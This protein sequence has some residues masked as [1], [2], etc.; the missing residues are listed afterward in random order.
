[1]ELLVILLVQMA[2]LVIQQATACHANII[3]KPAQARHLA[4][5]AIQ[6]INILW[7]VQFKLAKENISFILIQFRI[8]VFPL[9]QLT[10]ARQ[11]IAL[12]Q[13]LLKYG[14]KQTILELLVFK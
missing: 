7:V 13:A 6:A 11:P 8:L 14:L 12:M 4:H 10:K 1:M 5:N 3:A 9:I 2:C